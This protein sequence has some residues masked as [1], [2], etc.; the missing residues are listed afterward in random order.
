MKK[1]IVFFISVFILLQFFSTEENVQLKATDSDILIFEETSDEVSAIIKSS[2]YD[3]HSNYTNY[4]FIDKIFPVSLYVN[5][6]IR[7]GKRVLNFSEWGDYTVLEREI[8]IV[9]IDFDVQTER[10]PKKAYNWLYEEAKIT[11]HEKKLIQDWVY[12]IRE[13]LIKDNYPEM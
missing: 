13:R 6:N 3:C 9:A 8:A 2:C 4:S 7:N 1:L 12:S 11:E 10:M 5:N